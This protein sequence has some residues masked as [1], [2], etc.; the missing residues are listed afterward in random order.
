MAIIKQQENWNDSVQIGP[1]PKESV[2]QSFFFEK[3]F[4]IDSVVVQ[5][6]STNIDTVYDVKFRCEMRSSYGPDYL[7]DL[8]EDPAVSSS[9]HNDE[10]V[11]PTKVTFTLG[12]TFNAGFYYF[13]IASNR[14][15]KETCLLS[16]QKGGTFLGKY[17]NKEFGT[18]IYRNDRALFMEINGSWVGTLPKTNTVVRNAFTISIIQDET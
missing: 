14:Q 6:D 9:W 2:S 5:F 17:L 16:Y 3:D 1:Q 7:L 10:D 8:T 15:V 12:G 13:T 18:G 11:P 4:T